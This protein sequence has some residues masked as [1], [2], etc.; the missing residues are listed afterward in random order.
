MIPRSQYL[1]Q[2]LEAFI[3]DQVR[4]AGYGAD[5]FK[6]LETFPHEQ[7]RT[8][9][10]IDKTYI[11]SGF[12]YTRPP[13]RIEMGSMLSRRPCTFEVFVFAPGNSNA[14][15]NVTGVLEEVLDRRTIPILDVEDP[16][17][18]EIDRLDL[19]GVT[20]ARQPIPRPRPWEENVHLVTLNAED[21]Y[22]AQDE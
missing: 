9:Q 21:E 20:A 22:Y 6:I 16:L 4:A 18:P 11:A 5:E 3:T 8:E 2:S 1:T 7:I 12:N 15:E 10:D 19:L 14:G 13:R 17:R